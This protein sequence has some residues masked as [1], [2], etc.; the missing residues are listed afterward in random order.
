MALLCLAFGLVFKF[1]ELQV[2]PV[3]WCHTPWS[4]KIGAFHVLVFLG[5]NKDRV[6][7]IFSFNFSFTWTVMVSCDN[8]Q[9]Y[10]VLRAA[11]NRFS[12]L[13]GSVQYQLLDDTVKALC[14]RSAF[15]FSVFRKFLSDCVLQSL[16]PGNKGPEPPTDD[17]PNIRTA[18][19]TT[20]ASVFIYLCVTSMRPMQHCRNKPEVKRLLQC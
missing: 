3:V 10:V 13:N 1:K 18:S 8:S 17:L 5:R 2:L 7:C 6:S 4:A 9:Y 20:P 16:L 19:L 15:T 11:V 12:A 14:A